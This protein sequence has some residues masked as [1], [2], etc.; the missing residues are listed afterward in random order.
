MLAFEAAGLLRKKVRVFAWLWLCGKVQAPYQKW[1]PGRALQLRQTEQTAILT[2]S[3]HGKVV[4]WLALILKVICIRE[5]TRV[6][7]ISRLMAHWLDGNRH[8]PTDDKVRV[9]TASD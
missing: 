9:W 8:C 4:L 7:A 1:A 6:L 3:N 5:Q 2:V